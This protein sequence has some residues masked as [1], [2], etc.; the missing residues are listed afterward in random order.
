MATVFLATLHRGQSEWDLYPKRRLE[1]SS[2]CDAYNKHVLTDSPNRA[3]LIIIATNCTPH[4]IGL[5]LLAER[6]FRRYSRKCV[7]FDS[8]DNPSPLVGGLCASW[9]F[10][11]NERAACSVGWCY[12]HPNAAEP[13]IDP[14]KKVLA[15]KYLWSFQGSS[16]THPARK[17]LF[18]LKDELSFTS[19]TSATTL[20]NLM[21]QTSMELQAIFRNEYIQLLQDSDFIL[22]PRGRGTSSMRIFEAMRAGR[23]PV[24]ISDKWT[25]PPF[26]DWARISIR[27]KEDEVDKV[28]GLLREYQR[29]AREMG[30]RAQDEWNRVF[31]E[32]GLFHH[33]VEA[34]L[35]LLEKR[36]EQNFSERI[37]RA[38]YL[39]K[40][41]Y[42]QEIPRYLKN[43]FL[44][45]TNSWRKPTSR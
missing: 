17:K 19:D 20:P 38:K 4:P 6:Y 37:A 43:Q 9:P 40:K 30:N 13:H 32:E 36:N 23:V 15:G 44:R 28:P 21:G 24:I 10:P 16:Y 27:V 41:P 5:G 42:V 45:R 39:V 22:C 11:D 29:H 7:L 12:H 3:D 26:I 35:L 25:P 31:G 34:C 18:A 33:T 8:G 14:H 2:L 1:E